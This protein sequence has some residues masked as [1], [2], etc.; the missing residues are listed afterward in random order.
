MIPVKV[1][2][3]DVYSTHSLSH[4]AVMLV[5]YIPLLLLTFSSLSRQCWNRLNRSCDFPEKFPKTSGRGVFFFAGSDPANFSAL[6]VCLVQLCWYLPFFSSL[7][8]V[9]FEFTCWFL[10]GEQRY[11]FKS[12]IVCCL[13]FA[14]FS[15]QSL[16]AEPCHKGLVCLACPDAR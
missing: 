3:R 11:I 2:V 13:T 8:Q 12:C 4:T 7:S 10:A 14:L 6:Q 15:N 16:L 5:L 1:A 9:H